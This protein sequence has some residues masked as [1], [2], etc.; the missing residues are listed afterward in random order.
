MG[1]PR[2]KQGDHVLA[3]V[4]PSSSEHGLH[5][6]EETTVHVTENCQGIHRSLHGAVWRTPCTYAYATALMSTACTL[7]C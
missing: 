6:M 2:G 4:V 3:L 5:G 1:R 7:C